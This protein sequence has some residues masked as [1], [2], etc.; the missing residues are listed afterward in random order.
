MNNDSVVDKVKSDSFK[1]IESVSAKMKDYV[2]I[3][4]ASI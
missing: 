4:M 2:A 3:E 1:Q